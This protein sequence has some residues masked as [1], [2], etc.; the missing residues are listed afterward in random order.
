MKLLAHA[1][2]VRV[3]DPVRCENTHLALFL[4]LSLSISFLATSA[5]REYLHGNVDA[6]PLV[7]LQSSA[8][9]AV[10]CKNAEL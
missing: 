1:A 2:S 6:A 7:A 5:A 8:N 3:W 9:K 4:F 10:R